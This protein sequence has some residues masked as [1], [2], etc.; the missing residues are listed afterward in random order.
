[1][2]TVK[3]ILICIL[4]ACL[5]AVS[6]Q[7]F[8]VI[9]KTDEILS[10]AKNAGSSIQAVIDDLD[11]TVILARTTMVNVGLLIGRLE[12]TSEKWEA[13]A[14]KEAAY[15]KNLQAKSLE[16]INNLNATSDSLR[17]L[18]S[19]T[20]KQLNGEVLPA[21]SESIKIIGKSA[22]DMTSKIRDVANK[23]GENLDDLHS[24]LASPEWKEI[25][26]SINGSAESL[27]ASMK[28]LNKAAKE[29]PSV[30]QSVEK[31]AKTS[32]K[33]HKALIL[34]QIASMIGRIFF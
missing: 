1:V 25:L 33:Y 13:T 3:N 28:E 4:L 14:N 22:E 16:T 32:N 8:F 34:T 20:D 29:V 15:W 5:V 10:G 11:A 19:G 31:M 9:R 26:K 21:L 27:D 18:L 12:Q 17:D 2:N 6:V 23:S 7:A 30:A 24:I